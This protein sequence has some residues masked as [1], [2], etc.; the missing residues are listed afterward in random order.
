M[1]RRLESISVQYWQKHWDEG[2]EIKYSPCVVL[3]YRIIIDGTPQTLDTITLG[4]D[5]DF[6][7]YDEK[8]QKICKIAFEN[9]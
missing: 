2:E 5:H 4:K 6:S 9:L 7:S 8:I 3:T 1:E